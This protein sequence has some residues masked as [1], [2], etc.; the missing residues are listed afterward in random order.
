MSV[1][2]W[3]GWADWIYLLG[4]IESDSWLVWGAPGWEVEGLLLG[5]ETVRKSEP[6]KGECPERQWVGRGMHACV[7]RKR[8]FR[9]AQKLFFSLTAS[10]EEFLWQGTEHIVQPGLERLRGRCR[11]VKI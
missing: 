6:W 1:F 5:E 11:N 8:Q 9:E 4:T 10:Q 7:G 3:M 2:V